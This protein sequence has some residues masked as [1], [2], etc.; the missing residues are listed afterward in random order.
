LLIEKD[1][2]AVGIAVRGNNV[3][4]PIAVEIADRDEV[5]LT[6]GGI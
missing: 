1:R 3:S 6:P 5:G 2:Q 4:Q